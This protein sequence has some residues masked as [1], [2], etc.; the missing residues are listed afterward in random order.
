MSSC[1][2]S[3]Q[4]LLGRPTCPCAF[5]EVTSFW[6]EQSGCWLPLSHNTHSCWKLSGGPEQRAYLWIKPDLGNKPKEWRISLPWWHG[7]R[8]G[9]MS[10][11][12]CSCVN[13]CITEAVNSPVC[14]QLVKVGNLMGSARGFSAP[15]FPAGRDRLVFCRL[16]RASFLVECKG[17]VQ[18]GGGL[19]AAF[20]LSWSSLPEAFCL[21]P[22][23]VFGTELLV[24]SV[25]CC[26][27]GRP[28]G[29][30]T[31]SPASSHCLS[32]TT[33]SLPIPI[34]LWNVND[35]SIPRLLQLSYPLESM[36]IFTPTKV[37]DDSP[38]HRIGE[39]VE[40]EEG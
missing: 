13:C 15:G 32:L 38:L 18:T 40:V 36:G 24:A 1:G 33:R 14:V 37:Q 20:R 7:L 10:I 25:T 30:A 17:P 39:A 35:P 3:I 2:H 5:D 26:F 4:I 16:K 28:S 12:S 27:G 6:L 22:S 21:C 9:P 34:P 19:A 8:P 11:W 23:C 29:K 31:S